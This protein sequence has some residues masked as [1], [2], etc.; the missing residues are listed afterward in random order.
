MTAEQIILL[1]GL[2][3]GPAAWTGVTSELTKAGRRTVPV[4]LPGQG[5]GN[6]SATLADE[7]AAVLA[8]VDAY[9]G[10]SVVVGQGGGLLL[11]E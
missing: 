5:D 7:V 1:G 9:P 2:W 11:T 3:L 6:T 4:T 10:R 8:V